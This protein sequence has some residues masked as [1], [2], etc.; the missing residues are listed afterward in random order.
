MKFTSKTLFKFLFVVFLIWFVYTMFFSKIVEAAC[1]KNP[2]YNSQRNAYNHSLTIC[3]PIYKDKN[4]CLSTPTCK[5][6][7]NKYCAT[8][9]TPPTGSIC[10]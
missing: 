6:V 5:F 3:N 7:Y 9:I 1:V 10:K 2:N 8:A 4:K